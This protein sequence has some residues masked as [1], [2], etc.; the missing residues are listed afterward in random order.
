MFMFCQS[1]LRKAMWLFC[2]SELHSGTAVNTSPL[3]PPSHSPTSQSRA[4]SCGGRTAVSMMNAMYLTIRMETE[5]NT[6]IR[7]EPPN[8]FDFQLQAVVVEV[9]MMTYSTPTVYITMHKT[10]L[11]PKVCLY[12]REKYLKR[13]PT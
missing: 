7:P 8:N 13:D 5:K 12:N 1:I 10:C 6:P 3:R 2:A 9:M 4:S 11:E